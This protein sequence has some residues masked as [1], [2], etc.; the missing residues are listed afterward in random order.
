LGTGNIDLRRGRF[1]QKRSL[2]FVGFD[3]SERVW[4]SDVGLEHF[5][6]WRKEHLFGYW[7]GS[8]GLQ[9]HEI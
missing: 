2:L 4:F 9:P 5:Y 6:Q 7:G 8:V 3:S 1:A